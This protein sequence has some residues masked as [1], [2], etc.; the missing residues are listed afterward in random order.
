[1][2]L[3]TLR[4]ISTNTRPFPAEATAAAANAAA[5]AAAA[6]LDSERATTDTLRASIES[7][8][9]AH[10]Q[11]DRDVER[12][13]TE[14]ARHLE[15]RVALETRLRAE[16]ARHKVADDAALAREQERSALAA[17]AYTRPLLSST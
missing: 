11:L 13:E 16:F 5:A 12:G 15:Q 3:T 14:T 9:A 7:E 8:R 1:M 17:G 4:A 2:R 6:A 10:L